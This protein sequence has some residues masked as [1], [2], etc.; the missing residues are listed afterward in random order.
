[1][2]TNTV[3]PYRPMLT[4]TMLTHIAFASRPFGSCD[5]RAREN[6]CR[7]SMEEVHLD[8]RSFR[9]PAARA[10]GCY[11]LTGLLFRL[12]IGSRASAQR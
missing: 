11:V 12:R 6:L 1:M 9:L 4:L 8:R 3:A 7:G 2:P 10:C 5:R